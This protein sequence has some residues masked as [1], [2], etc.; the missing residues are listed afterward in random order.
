[1]LPDFDHITALISAIKELNTNIKIVILRQLQ[2][3][4]MRRGTP[5]LGTKP[6]LLAKL[7]TYEKHQAGK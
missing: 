6:E 1:M 3:E 5:K 4:C 7:Q 2:E